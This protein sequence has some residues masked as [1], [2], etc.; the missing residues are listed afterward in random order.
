MDKQHIS[1]YDKSHDISLLLSEERKQRQLIDESRRVM[2]ARLFDSDLP[3]KQKTALERAIVTGHHRFTMETQPPLTL[4]KMRTFFEGIIRNTPPSAEE[5]PAFF[6][7]Q[8][9]LL[10]NHGIETCQRL[11]PTKEP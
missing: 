5:N 10:V 6:R 1:S 9:A 8:F 2:L 3:A 4:D 11:R 7:R